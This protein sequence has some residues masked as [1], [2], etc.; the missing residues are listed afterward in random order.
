MKKILLTAIVISSMAPSV[1]AVAYNQNITAIF[2]GGNP[3]T[4]WTTTD[5]DPNGFQ[6]GL[7]AKNRDNASTANVNGVYSYTTGYATTSPAP[8]SPSARGLWNW[9]FSINSGSSGNLNATFDYYVAIDTDLSAGTSFVYVNALTGFADNSYGINATGNGQGLEGSAAVFAST[10]N[11]AQQSQNIV[12]YPGQSP[13]LSGIYTY[14]LFA[15]AQGGGVNGARRAQVDITV[16]VNN[17]PDAGSSL[18]LL[19]ISVAGLVGFSFRKRMLA[20]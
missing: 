2:G 11:I 10:N 20:A 9:E 7:R 18:A 12:F 15:V 17:V 19:G 5:A 4:G 3:N 1:W 14:E 16:Q 13:L 6:L 8:P